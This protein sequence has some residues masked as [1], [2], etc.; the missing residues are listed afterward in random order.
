MVPGSLLSPNMG[1]LAMLAAGTVP[2]NPQAVLA[3]RQVQELL[4][5]LDK[6]FDI[7]ILDTPPVLA[8]SDAIPLL[9]QSD[10]VVVVARVNET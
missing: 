8:V 3:T 5:E 6:R 2:A 9:S 1:R 10:G 7:V 4:S